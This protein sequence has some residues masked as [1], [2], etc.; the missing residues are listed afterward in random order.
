MSM[1]R[2]GRESVGIRA[3]VVTPLDRP[4]AGVEAAGATGVAGEAGVA[5]EAGT[6]GG[7]GAEGG[8]AGKA[9]VA[10]AVGAAD[11]VRVA[12]EATGGPLGDV[13][14]TV[15]KWIPGEVL[16]LYVAGVTMIG[17]PSWF[18][19]VVGVMLAPATVLL[20]AF[21][22]SGR[23]PPGSR[24]GVRAGLG[25]LTMVLWSLTVPASGWQSWPLVRDNRAAV[26]LAA[27]VVGLL[28]GLVAEGVSRWVDGRPA[29]HRR[30]AGTGGPP[31]RAAQPRPEAAAGKPEPAAREQTGWAAAPEAPPGRRTADPQPLRM[32]SIPPLE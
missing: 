16:A 21:A 8:P 30:H 14:D 24:T 1:W 12:G 5:S 11:E 2:V 6:A 25:F 27:G 17:K 31:G 9:G 7:T 3:A 32:P 15:A 22:N 28:F 19:L 26:A 20:A 4:V 29:V 18:W 10:G 23:F 13:A